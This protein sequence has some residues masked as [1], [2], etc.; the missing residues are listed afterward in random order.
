MDRTDRTSKD[1]VF[2]AE[3]RPHRS[4][5]PRGFLLLML[6]VGGVSFA[7]GIAFFLQGAWPVLGFFGLDVLAIYFA[8]RISFSSGRAFETIELY[9]E[10]LKVVRHRPF[11]AAQHWSFEPYWLRVE[12]VGLEDQPKRI[13]LRQRSKELYIGDLMPPGE[14]PGFARVLQDALHQARNPGFA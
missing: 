14:R 11:H 12:L 8:F 10:R 2:R 7:A 13:A 4:L 1:L 9:P 6:F 5:S 3:L